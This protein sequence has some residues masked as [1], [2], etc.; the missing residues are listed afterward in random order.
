MNYTPNAKALGIGGAWRLGSAHGETHRQPAIAGYGIRGG[1]GGMTVAAP[2]ILGAVIAG[3]L[4]RRMGGIDKLWIELA[5]EPLI[6]RAA[7]RLAGQTGR[8]IINATRPDERLERLGYP[9]A[10]DLE[11]NFQGPLAGFQAA[12][13]WARMHAPDVTHLV[14]APADSPFFPADLTERLI[15]SGEGRTDDIA[16]A[17]CEVSP[18]PVFGLWPVSCLPALE[19]FLDSAGSLKVMDFVRSRNGRRVD[20]EPGEPPAF[21]NINTSEDYETSVGLMREKANRQ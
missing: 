21:F 18:Q 16:I 17:F 3:G 13:H 10:P 2:N 15:A 20:F 6:L 4:S 1:G 5:G 12:L 8:V 7:P 11:Q 19:Q 9:I 14:T